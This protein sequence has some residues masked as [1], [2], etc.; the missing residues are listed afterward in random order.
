MQTL[1]I[2]RAVEQL[3]H[4]IQRRACHNNVSRAEVI[5]QWK[6]IQ[7][8]MEDTITE[9]DKLYEA[10]AVKDALSNKEKARDE[11]VLGRGTRW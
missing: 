4:L 2:H 8:E 1:W 9:M 6:K 11:S 5:Y 10:K 3:Q 7:A